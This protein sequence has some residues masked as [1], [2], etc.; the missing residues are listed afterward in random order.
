MLKL[1]L[2]TAYLY[3]IY[4]YQELCYFG[5]RNGCVKL[6]NSFNYTSDFQYTNEVVGKP[7]NINN[8]LVNILK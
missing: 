7:E 3:D 2:N 4:L 1:F 8:Y 5:N 6:M